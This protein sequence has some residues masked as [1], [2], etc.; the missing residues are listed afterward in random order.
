MKRQDDRGIGIRQDV[1]SKALAMSSPKSW[2]NLWFISSEFTG[3]LF[4]TFIS[5]VMLELQLPLQPIANKMQWK[6]KGTN[7]LSMD[8]K[9]FAARQSWITK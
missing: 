5:S 8:F 1:P 7:F 6:E 4:S 2:D 3:V 9:K